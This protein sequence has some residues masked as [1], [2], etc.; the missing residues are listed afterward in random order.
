MKTI[1]KILWGCN[2][3]IL[4]FYVFCMVLC[5]GG[6]L[7]WGKVSLAALEQF[8]C[9][10]CLNKIGMVYAIKLFLGSLIISILV[11]VAIFLL[12]KKFYKENECYYPVGW[13]VIGLCGLEYLVWEVLS[14]YISLQ[15]IYLFILCSIVF[16]SY[17]INLCR[18]YEAKYILG[19]LI[20]FYPIFWMSCLYCQPLLFS[21]YKGLA[22][23]L[24]SYDFE[25]D[26]QTKRNLIV[27]YVESFNRDFSS[28]VYNGKE[29]NVNDEDA[30]IF[31]YFKEGVEQ[32]FTKVALISSFSGVI[33]S[34]Y[35][36]NHR[37]I[38]QIIKDKD[39][40]MI[41]VKG[42]DIEFSDTLGFL[43]NIGFS[44]ENIIGLSKN[45]F[46]DC[47]GNLRGCRFSKILK[48]EDALWWG[49]EDKVTFSFF[50]RKIEELDKKKPFFAVMFTVDLHD[51]R[52]PSES[53]FE[54]IKTENITNL[55]N[56]IAWF[57]KQ[58]F[59]E[60]TS[61]IILADHAKPMTKN[62]D[63]VPLYNAFFNL[64]EN[65]IENLDTNRTFNQTDMFLTMLEIMGFKLPEG[66]MEYSTTLFSSKKTVAE[67]FTNTQMIDEKE[68]VSLLHMLNESKRMTIVIGRIFNILLQN[69]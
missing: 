60:N 8:A 35:T 44:E 7:F 33:P 6:R 54:N 28:I 57:K 23:T 31:S 53:D 65:L 3:V 42:G 25:F 15:S 30:V 49:V 16:L 13:F 45:K 66:Q 40:Q 51:G 19:L 69:M 14:H 50:E 48:E 37:T 61:L 38:S 62:K 20:L 18:R 68:K 52:N 4:F 11:V 34:Y 9:P 32:D 43:K 12:F 58:D 36:K 67:R 17:L 59:Y 29:Y 63:N 55:N 27:V 39:Y 56:F 2:G 26:E 46:K 22:Q 24:N 1:H 10:M 47:I 5:V 41:F 21:S 64:P